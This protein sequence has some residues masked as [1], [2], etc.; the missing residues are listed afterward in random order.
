MCVVVLNTNLDPSSRRHRHSPLGR[1]SAPSRHFHG[2]PLPSG[3]RGDG[4]RRDGTSEE[5]ACATP[6]SPIEEWR[7]TRRGVASSFPQPAEPHP[8][9]AAMI[10]PRD[11]FVRC[12]LSA[13]GWQ[14]RFCGP[15]PMEWSDLV[16]AS[17]TERRRREPKGTGGSVCTETSTEYDVRM[18][19]SLIT[20][21]SILTA[22]S[23]TGNA[24]W[25]LASGLPSV[26]PS[27]T[28]ARSP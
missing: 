22:L 3:H 19:T 17:Q 23:S 28:R 9:L 8:T 7:D 16:N 24:P 6:Q 13:G 18:C 15:R 20:R 25:Y 2:R 21:S 1:S 10:E 12:T 4:A 11:I 27:A 14:R 5:G 26:A